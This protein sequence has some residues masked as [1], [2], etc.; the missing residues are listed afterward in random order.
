MN[1]IRARVVLLVL[2]VAACGGSD[3]EPEYRW[4]EEDTARSHDDDYRSAPPPPAR[5][6]YE[7]EDDDERL[8]EYERRPSASGAA[9]GS[10]GG[11]RSHR[12]AEGAIFAVKKGVFCDE[13]VRACYTLKG[14]HP[15]VT[16]KQFG[17]EAGRRLARR[18]DEEGKR[19]PRAIVRAGDGF[20]CDRL[21]E[22]CYDREGAS[23]RET[24]TEFGHD[25]A[26]ELADRIDR[27]RGGSG[28]RGGVVFSP[29]QGV[30]CDEQVAA[31]Y[32]GDAAHPGHTKQQFGADAARDL[33]RRIDGGKSRGD[34]IY[35]PRGGVVCDRLGRACYDRDGV[36]VNATRDEFGKD[37]AVRLTERLD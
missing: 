32:V 5:D 21:S 23:L 28:R 29:R 24:R 26:E 19:G 14:G 12:G 8:R 17:D 15:G 37:A 16:E 31:C 36:N 25:A 27:P 2:F 18:I 34:G 35:R 10:Y 13:S 33:E 9:T 7:D 22:V 1:M 6:R 20:V 11:P 30:S 4:E 3:P